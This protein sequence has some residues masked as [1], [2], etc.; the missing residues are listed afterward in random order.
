M[1]GCGP[2]GAGEPMSW[3]EFRGGEEVRR[4][5]MPT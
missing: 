4:A 5:R 1:N 3:K 2:G